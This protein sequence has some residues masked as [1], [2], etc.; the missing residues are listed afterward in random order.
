MRR[1]LIAIVAM[2]ALSSCED[3]RDFH[4]VEGRVAECHVTRPNQIEAI[5]ARAGFPLLSTPHRYSCRLAK[6]GSYDFTVEQESES[7][8]EDFSDVP[9]AIIQKAIPT[10]TVGYH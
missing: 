7:S 1:G 2:L 10:S 4:A 6:D 3:V 8:L 9:S 5:D